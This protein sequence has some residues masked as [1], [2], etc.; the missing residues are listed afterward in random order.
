V[1]GGSLELADEA[2]SCV[3]ARGTME[4]TPEED[5]PLAEDVDE[6]DLEDLEDLDVCPGMEM[7]RVL[8]GRKDSCVGVGEEV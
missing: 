1:E 3:R 8:L 6:R 7:S 2:E 5:N 4:E